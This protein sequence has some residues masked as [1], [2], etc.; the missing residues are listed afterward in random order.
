MK[1]Y[2]TSPKMYILI[3]SDLFYTVSVVVCDGKIIIYYIIDFLNFI[4]LNTVI[5]SN[6][7]NFCL[8]F[9][10]TF[11]VFLVESSHVSFILL[12]SSTVCPEGNWPDDSL[13]PQVGWWASGCMMASAVGSHAAW[14]RRSWAPPSGHRTS[15]SVRGSNRS[16]VG[17]GPPGGAALTRTHP[18]QPLGPSR[19]GRTTEPQGPCERSETFKT[20]L[21]TGLFLSRPHPLLHVR[22]GT[23]ADS[24]S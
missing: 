2:T 8:D 1:R 7:H 12:Y 18:T 23:L 15:E 3:G 21:F 5:F 11:L 6:S 16:R 10:E 22:L 9:S 20:F 17:P 4:C 19:Q 14:W 13:Y 24:G